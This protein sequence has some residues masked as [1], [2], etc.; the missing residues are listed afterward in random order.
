MSADAV[1]P[2]IPQPQHTQAAMTWRTE[3]HP[4][5]L[6]DAPLMASH[7]SPGASDHQPACNQQQPMYIHQ[8]VMQKHHQPAYTH[9]P[10]YHHQQ[11]SDWDQQLWYAS[12]EDSERQWR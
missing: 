6:I 7:H 2:S 10:D 5:T 9:G 12:Q 11:H 1:R 8:Q 4:Q 3:S